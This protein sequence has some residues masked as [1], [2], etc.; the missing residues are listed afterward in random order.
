MSRL[1]SIVAKLRLLGDNVTVLSSDA[2][3]AKPQNKDEV[4]CYNISGSRLLHRKYDKIL[5]EVITDDVNI[6]KGIDGAEEHLLDRHL[7][8]KSKYNLETV[9]SIIKDI[10][11]VVFRQISSSYRL[12]TVNGKPISSEVLCSL[13]IWEHINDN[14]IALYSLANGQSILIRAD[15]DG[16][17]I[18]ILSGIQSYDTVCIGKHLVAIKYEGIDTVK[19]YGFDKKI[20]LVVKNGILKQ[21]TNKGET[22]YLITDSFGNTLTGFKGAKQLY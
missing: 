21:K 19:L 15:T 12:A 18:E 1:N 7:V 8:I 10:Y 22:M 6:I 20:K 3:I 11:V 2:I 4:V 5:P 13:K 14:I 16:N 9:E 17:Q